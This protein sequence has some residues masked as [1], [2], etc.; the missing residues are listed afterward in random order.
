M[1]QSLPLA[2]LEFISHGKQQTHQINSPCTCLVMEKCCIEIQSTDLIIWK[3]SFKLRTELS[4]TSSTHL[5]AGVRLHM[6]DCIWDTEPTE[7]KC[8][9][10]DAHVKFGLAS[11]RPITVPTW[12][13]AYAAPATLSE[14]R[15]SC[16]ILHGGSKKH[17]TWRNSGYTNKQ[18]P[19][20]GGSFKG[21]TLD[22]IMSLL[23]I[24]HWLVVLRLTG[25]F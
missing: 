12:H 1:T 6:N 14:S 17:W 13:S 8:L 9:Y 16:S 10:P 18:K 15:K 20:I 19:D 11:K 24:P 2:L 5:L 25:G 4:I 7:Q 3:D 22:S 21:G 23:F